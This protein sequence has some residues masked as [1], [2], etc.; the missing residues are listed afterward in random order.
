MFRSPQAGAHNDG[1]DAPAPPAAAPEA[2]HLQLQEQYQQL[3]MRLQQLELRQQQ[4]NDANHHQAPPANHAA[5]D[6]AAPAAADGHEPHFAQAEVNAVRNLKFPPFW[7]GNPALWFAQVEAAFALHNVNGD[8]TR[9]R[10]I[11]TQLDSRTLPAIADII[12]NPPVADKYLAIKARIMSSFA[13]TTESKLRQLLRGLDPS[14]DKPTLLLQR[15]RNLAGGHVGDALLRTLFL[16]QLPEYVR[17]VL[18]ISGDIDLSTLAQQADRV[19]EATQSSSVSAIHQQ[20]QHSPHPAVA[21]VARDTAM[22]DLLAAVALLTNEV[23]ALKSDVRSR[24]RSTSRPRT[25]QQQICR[26][27][28]KFGDR[29]RNCEAPCSKAPADQEN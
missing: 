1:G 12:S 23:K 4:G 19:M 28:A 11:I 2:A 14:N 18:A 3:L 5:A 13:D 22:T 9:Y 26:F 20:A 27:H 7:A 15:I 8:T 21:S 10:H 16:E 6:P 24:G 29:A 17:G 25:T